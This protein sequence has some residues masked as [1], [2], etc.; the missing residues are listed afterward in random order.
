[1]TSTTARRVSTVQRSRD[2]RL[3]ERLARGCDT[4]AGSRTIGSRIRTARWAEHDDRMREGA[5]GRRAPDSAG[6]AARL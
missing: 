3:R 2:K 4:V 6:D 5:S 1:V